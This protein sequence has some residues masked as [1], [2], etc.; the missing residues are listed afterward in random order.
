MRSSVHAVIAVKSLELAKSRL[1]DRLHPRDRPRLVLAMLADTVDAATATPEIGSVT[2]V[3]P[4]PR[5]ADL[6]RGLGAHVHPEPLDPDTGRLPDAAP[7]AAAEPLDA[8]AAPTGYRAQPHDPMTYLRGE[9]TDVS[10]ARPRV[11]GVPGR[12]LHTAE[13]DP[14][15][16]R[17]GLNA[18]LSAAADAVRRRHGPV[19]LLA[20]QADLPALRPTE[21]SGAL[22]AAGQCRRA[23]VA[24]HTGTGTV[25]LLVRDGSTPLTPLFGAD[26]ARRHI[27]A[28]AV[29]LLG[30]WPGL[31]QDV[32]TADDLGRAMALGVGVNTRALLSELGVSRRRDG[33]H[34]VDRTGP[35]VRRPA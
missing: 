30:D 14:V 31:R 7:R 8:M 32:D 12:A 16:P 35:P 27:A 21:L 28:G 22:A 25:A 13:F 4:D 6:V 3:T 19:E 11:G 2:V 5:V 1:A 34:S 20:L 9:E 24:D 23:V 33:K 10:A 26:S 29:E 17:G 15:P 18:A